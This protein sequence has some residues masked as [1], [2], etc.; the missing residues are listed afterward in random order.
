MLKTQ[1]QSRYVRFLAPRPGRDKD[2]KVITP[3]T[4]KGSKQRA[5][6]RSRPCGGKGVGCWSPQQD[7]KWQEKREY[8]LRLEQG[9]VPVA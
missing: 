4:T 5:Q 8:K 7:R 9:L 2:M 6:L 3:V 1:W